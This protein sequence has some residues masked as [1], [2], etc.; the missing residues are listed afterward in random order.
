MLE[1]QIP[2]QRKKVTKD[3]LILKLKA[4]MEDGASKRFLLAICGAPGAGK[5]TLA[6]WIVDHWNQLHPEQAVL[7]PMDGYHFSNEK[8]QEMNLLPLKGIPATF[9]ADSFIKK[10]AELRMYPDAEHGYP[11]FD[12]SIEASIQD[13]I[14]VLPRHKLLVIEGNYLLLE[15]APWNNLKQYFDASWYI[16][17][18]EKLILP[19]LLE[20][21]KQGGKSDSAAFEKV[22][23]TDLPNARLIS[24]SLSRA[25]LVISANNFQDMDTSKQGAL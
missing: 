16:D 12:R 5:S 20:R 1:S 14:K 8:L 2:I 4:S 9:D 19:R 22:N 18:S 3:D 7:V 6:E 25:D 23:S 17:A 10:I 15:S 24:K 13:A 21:H 11:R